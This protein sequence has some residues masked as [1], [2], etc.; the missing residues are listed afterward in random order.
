MFGAWVAT[1]TA[2]HTESVWLWRLLVAVVALSAAQL[3][4]A[5]DLLRHLLLRWLG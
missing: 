3:L 2:A 1:R 4:G 5:F